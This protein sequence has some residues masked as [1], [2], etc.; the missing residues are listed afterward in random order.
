[1]PHGAHGPHSPSQADGSPCRSNRLLKQAAQLASADPAQAARQHREA[2][3][4]T[5][6][7]EPTC[8]RTRPVPLTKPT[9]RRMAIGL[10]RAND[11]L[12]LFSK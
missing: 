8:A 3:P 10:L 12:K 4:T 6:C 9:P 7:P 2:M 11:Q 5:L 1:M